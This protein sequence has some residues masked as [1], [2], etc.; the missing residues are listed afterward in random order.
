[1]ALKFINAN[2][3][4]ALRSYILFKLKGLGPEVCMEREAASAPTPCTAPPRFH[5]ASVFGVTCFGML[6]VCHL[7]CGSQEKTQKTILCTWLTEMFLELLAATNVAS[8]GTIPAPGG[9]GAGAGTG[10][11]SS[12]GSD[13]DRYRAVVKEFQDFLTTY[14]VRSGTGQM[15]KQHGSRP[16]CSP[17]HGQLGCWATL[18]PSDF[19][20]AHPTLLI[21]TQPDSGSGPFS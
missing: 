5:L 2:R 10:G 21:H 1:M 18:V 13:A 16:W 12:G 11:A 8:S 19:S 6:V 4:D 7:H 14:E 3:K 20:A 9:A 17:F 15:S